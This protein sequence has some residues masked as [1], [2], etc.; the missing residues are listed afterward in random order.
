MSGR[1]PIAIRDPRV[2]DRG[3]RR[4]RLSGLRLRRP[5]PV[6]RRRRWVELAEDL[7][8][9]AVPDEQDPVGSPGRDPVAVL[10]DGNPEDIVV[11]AV[12]GAGDLAVL[13]AVGVPEPDGLVARGP[14]DHRLAGDPAHR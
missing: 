8:V 10:R 5:G 6:C 4:P 12:E 3:G 1:R 11:R 7:A 9:L 2:T 14:R 13:A